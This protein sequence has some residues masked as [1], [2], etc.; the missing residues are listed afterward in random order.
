[1]RVA[2]YQG[3]PK[4][5][6]DHP[7]DYIS[8]RN[9]NKSF[10]P[11]ALAG[12]DTAVLVAVIVRVEGTGAAGVAVASVAVAGVVVAGV[13]VLVVGGGRSTE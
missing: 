11:A 4:F 6:E 13:G 9:S 10:L 1:M 5:A 2:Q 3:Q 7:V 12:R 8:P